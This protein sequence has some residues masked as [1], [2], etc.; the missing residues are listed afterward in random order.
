MDDGSG[1]NDA[2][3]VFLYVLPKYRS[4]GIGMFLLDNA[5]SW[6]RDAGYSTVIVNRVHRYFSIWGYKTVEDNRMAFTFLGAL[7][8]L[9]GQPNPYAEIE[10]Q[11]I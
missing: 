1:H 7:A 9:W 2:E 10:Q 6:A 4:K 5:M 3:L 8:P 11:E